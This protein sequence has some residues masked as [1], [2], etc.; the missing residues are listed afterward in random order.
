MILQSPQFRDTLVDFRLQGNPLT[1][2]NAIIGGDDRLWTKRNESI[3]Q[4]A[5]GKTGEDR[6]VNRSDPETGKNS[7]DAF[8]HI[9]KKNC[10]WAAAIDTYAL[11]HIGTTL[12]FVEE[13]LVSA[14]RR[15]PGFRFPDEGDAV[16][17]PLAT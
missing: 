12:D 2:P 3:I 8:D 17:A 10:D 6:V 14:K 15:F 13:H 7:D 5:S 11:E 9:G 16:A 4:R 1:A